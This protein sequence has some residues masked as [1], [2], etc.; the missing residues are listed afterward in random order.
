MSQNQSKRK[1]N[2]GQSSKGKGVATSSESLAQP[3]HSNKLVIRGGTQGKEGK[4]IF[5]MATTFTQE[6]FSRQR[7]R[8]G[9]VS[10]IH[11]SIHPDW[12]YYFYEHVKI[13]FGSNFSMVKLVIE[14]SDR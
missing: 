14:C 2:S 1:R 12:V 5:L 11:D 4:L 3:T 9:Y 13:T 10:Y 7:T 8:L 6:N